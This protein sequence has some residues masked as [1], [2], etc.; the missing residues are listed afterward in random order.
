LGVLALAKRHGVPRLEDACAA[1]LELKVP[2]YRFV[3]RYVDRTNAP[4]LGLKQTDRLIRELEHYRDVV[5]RITQKEDTDH[6]SH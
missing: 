6:E 5:R 1:A 2:T 3:K 4:E